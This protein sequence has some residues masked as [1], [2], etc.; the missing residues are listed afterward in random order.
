MEDLETT[1]NNTQRLLLTQRSGITLEFY[2]MPGNL[3]ALKEFK[4]STIAP[5]VFSALILKIN[6]LTFH[7]FK[8]CSSPLSYINER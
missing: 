8:F 2:V 1:P 6:F 4:T 3:P 7:T 5:L